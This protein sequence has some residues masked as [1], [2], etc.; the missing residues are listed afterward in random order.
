MEN[1][2]QETEAFLKKKESGETLSSEDSEKLTKAL[3]KLKVE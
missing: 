2:L 1:E 3:E